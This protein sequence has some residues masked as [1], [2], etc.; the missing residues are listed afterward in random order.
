[1]RFEKNVAFMAM[2]IAAYLTSAY[3]VG[4]RDTAPKYDPAIIEAMGNATNPPF[5]NPNFTCT[6]L[7]I[8]FNRQD[9][10]VSASSDPVLYEAL[11]EG[12]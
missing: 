10:V 11:E 2:V 12:N 7:A 3:A 5:G 8:A 1:M 6:A 4:R 9:A